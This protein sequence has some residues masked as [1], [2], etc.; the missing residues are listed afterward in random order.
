MRNLFNDDKLVLARTWFIDS[1]LQ[2]QKYDKMLKHAL[3]VFGDRG[4]HISGVGRDH[5]PTR[6]KH[7]LRSAARLV[8]WYSDM[9]WES[10]PPY[11]RESTMRQLATQCAD[12]HGFG[13][14]GPQGSVCK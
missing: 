1:C 11:Y 9:A 14:Y 5:F 6:T 13:F 2:S 3:D 8:T 10:K 7:A 12:K 4:A